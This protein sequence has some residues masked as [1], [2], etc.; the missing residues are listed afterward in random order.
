ME[1]E[2]LSYVALAPYLCGGKAWRELRNRLLNGHKFVR[3]APVG[4]YFVDFLCREKKVIVEVDGGTH[5][6][7]SETVSDNRRTV[8]LRRLGYRIFRVTNGDI[9]NSLDGVLDELLALIEGAHS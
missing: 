1:H 5:S 4:P 6:T 2:P 7:S 8:H 3:Q 9:Y